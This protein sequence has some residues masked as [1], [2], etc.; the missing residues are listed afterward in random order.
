MITLILKIIRF[1]FVRDR[2]LKKE[3]DF[4][5]DFQKFELSRNGSPVYTRIGG[6]LAQYAGRFVLISA[7]DFSTIL[8]GEGSNE[9][10]LLEK[11]PALENKDNINAYIATYYKMVKDFYDCYDIKKNQDIDAIH[12]INEEFSH[13]KLVRETPTYII[14][15]SLT[16]YYRICSSYLT[17]Y[18]YHNK[19]LDMKVSEA[20]LNTYMIR[21]YITNLT[22]PIVEAS[23]HY[24]EDL[25]IIEKKYGI[26]IK[27]WCNRFLQIENA[28][29][30]KIHDEKES[31]DKILLL[32]QSVFL[33][34]PFITSIINYTKIDYLKFIQFCNNIFVKENEQLF[35]SIIK[36]IDSS[37]FRK[38]TFENF[39]IN[40]KNNRT[41]NTQLDKEF[42]ATLLFLA[43]ETS[44]S[45]IP[46]CLMKFVFK[47]LLVC[48]NKLVF[49]TI[50]SKKNDVNNEYKNYPPIKCVGFNNLSICIDGAMKIFKEN[51]FIIAQ[52]SFEPTFVGENGYINIVDS[53]ICKTLLIQALLIKSLSLLILKIDDNNFNNDTFRTEFSQLIS[54]MPKKHKDWIKEYI[55][56]MFYNHSKDILKDFKRI[57]DIDM[58]TV[59]QRFEN[60]ILLLQ[61]TINSINNEEQKSIFYKF[62]NVNYVHGF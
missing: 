45:F 3:Y 46:S 23:Y 57:Q 58:K 5:P 61:R 47:R 42:Q 15:N 41:S 54:N 8:M 59:A 36:I 60:H 21:S 31:I 26:K 56:G 9:S 12:A 33:S 55:L 52:N 6:S 35:N 49:L 1:L 11:Y 34:F 20:L 30:G 53:P 51:T 17:Y 44:D 2:V 27:E 43:T 24:H 32:A 16:I 25:S 14:L 19:E 4:N 39:L 10:Q 7:N 62:C 40:E 50:L 18:R 38:N 22:Y 13:H 37:D 29:K 48:K 28:L